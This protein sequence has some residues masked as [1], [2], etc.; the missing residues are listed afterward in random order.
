MAD[1][2]HA[3]T[4]SL[5]GA[6]AEPTADPSK[7][8]L[9]FAGVRWLGNTLPEAELEVKQ[10][11]PESDDT[12][13]SE[14]EPIENHNLV[15]LLKRPNPYMSS[16]TMWKAFANDWIISGNVHFIKFRNGFGQVVQLWYEPFKSIRPRWVNDNQ[17]EYLPRERSDSDRS[18]EIPDSTENFINYYEV[19]RGGTKHRLAVADVIHFR[20]GIDPDNTRCGLSG[21]MTIL[22]EIYGD[23]AVADYAGG[24]LAAKG[25]PPG[26]L[27][28]DPQIGMMTQAEVDDLGM[29]LER[30]IKS[31]RPLIVRGGKFERMG[32]TPE[33]IDSRVSR[34]MSEERFSAVTGIPAIVLNFGSGMERSIYNN[35]A[36]ADRRAVKQ[37]LEPLWWHIAQ[38][39]TAQVLPDFDQDEEHF[40]EFCLDEVAALQED[41]NAKW[42]RIGQ[43]YQ[44]GWIKRSEARKFGNLESEDG[45]DVYYVKPGSETV[46]LEDEEEKR[47]MALEPKPDPLALAGQPDRKLLNAAPMKIKQFY[48]AK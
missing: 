10:P 41:E 4:A 39:M 13:S 7:S 9:V 36:E 32:L 6:V 26:V 38:E 11:A 19:D 2:Q 34:Y 47:E 12:A 42:K 45:D 15:K 27:S 48:K 1:W 24:V 14:D 37:Y 30:Q 3:I 33:E 28:I 23:S 8:S 44:D 46:T 25:V 22:R 5:P 17:G 40:V 43:A 31:G 18:V 29:R 21:M 20:D 35:M 16:S